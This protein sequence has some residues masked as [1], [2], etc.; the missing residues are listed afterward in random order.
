VSGAEG[1]VAAVLPLYDEG[2][3]IGTLVRRMPDQIAETIVVDDGSTDDGPALA[4]SAGATLVRLDGRRGVG[5]AIRAGI[6]TARAHGH[7]GVVIMAA[8]GKDDP[9]EAP[10]LIARLRAGDDYVQGSRFLRG[11]S[12]R[13]L[14][15]ARLLMIKGYTLVFRI[16]IDRP[17]T[18]VTNGFRA[19]RLALL[20]D[21]RIDIG[22]EWLDHYEL[23]YYIHYKAMTLGY[24][25]SEVPVSKTYPAGRRPYSKIRPFRDWWSIIRPIVLLRLGLR[26]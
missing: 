15:R 12:H 25:T 3:V 22:Q 23:E 11:G 20:D 17:G 19:Y 26:R 5:A 14:P 2:P 1:T 7:W 24:R 10:L 16:L 18:D 21:P 8:N 4:A 9:A 6:D 13:N